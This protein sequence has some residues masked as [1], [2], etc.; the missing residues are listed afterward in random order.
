MNDTRKGIACIIASAAG[1]ALM[2]FFVRLCDDYGPDVSAFQKSFF[3]NI[4][5][6]SLALL[7]FLR[8]GGHVR[9]PDAPCGR[10][11]TPGAWLCLLLRCIA[12]TAGIFANFYALSRIPVGEAMCLNKTAPFFTILFSFL[13]LGEKI[14]K[15]RASLLLLAFAGAALVAK[16]GMRELGS[17]AAFCGLFGGLCAGAAYACVRE[18]G[19]AGMSG[20]FIVLVFS[21]FSTLASLPF[22][23]G[24]SYTPMTQTQLLI[25]IGAGAG[26]AIGQF[27]V[28]AAYRF[29]PAGKIAVF[30]YLNIVFA[31]AL[32]FA[33][34]GQTPDL[35]SV[36]G[37]AMIVVAAT[38][39]LR[40][41]PANA[42]VASIAP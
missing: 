37:F 12:G 34:L 27:G 17:F 18:L 8:S 24:P 7:M 20:S 42:G 23:L 16:P 38:P 4:V 10:L 25:M 15:R 5:A 19:V 2:G 3:R 9:R 40:R 30:D 21:A 39:Q 6:F 22:M 31:A 35:V 33:F 29:A 26:A 11:E 28:T 36:A 1:F 14:S 13:F 32:G 41:H